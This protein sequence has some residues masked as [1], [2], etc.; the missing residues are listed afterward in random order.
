M[1]AYVDTPRLQMFEQDRHL[2]GDFF[3]MFC[4]DL[5]GNGTSRRVYQY[6]MDSTLV[7]KIEFKEAEKRIMFCN[8]VEWDVYSEMMD[9]KA[10]A[11]FMAPVIALS[12]CGRILLQKKTTPLQKNTKLP[13]ILPAIFGD[14][15]VENW[16]L[17]NG[18]VVCHDYANHR[19]FRLNYKRPDQMIKANWWSDSGN[20]PIK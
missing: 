17:L 14:T 19:A 5:I 4:G 8:V 9:C 16:G 1:S 6:T 3:D 18:K 10:I 20:F 12:P 11:K 7:V 15:K 2:L 13:Q